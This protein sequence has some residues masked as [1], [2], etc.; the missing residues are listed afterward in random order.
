MLQ[1][2][3]QLTTHQNLDFKAL[4]ADQFKKLAAGTPYEI[5]YQQSGGNM[6]PW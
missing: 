2:P 1:D 4:T 6:A 5:I 3:M